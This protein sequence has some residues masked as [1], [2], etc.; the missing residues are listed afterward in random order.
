LSF[1]CTHIVLN[2]NEANNIFLKRD[3]RISI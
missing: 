3:S 2:F 1:K